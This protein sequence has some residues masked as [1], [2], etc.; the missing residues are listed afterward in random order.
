MRRK[1]MA[2]SNEMFNVANQWQYVKA[3]KLAIFN[4]RK[5]MAKANQSMYEMAGSIKIISI[6]EAWKYLSK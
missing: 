5:S 1:P 4:N 2:I 3:E 6:M